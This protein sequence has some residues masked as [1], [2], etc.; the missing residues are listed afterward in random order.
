MA[1]ETVLVLG[2]SGGVGSAAVDLARALGARVLVAVSSQDKLEF[3]KSC[4]AEAGIVY[5]LRLESAEQKKA[6][7]AELKALAGASGVD[8][9]LD[10]VG[11]EYSEPALRCLASLGR[12]LVVGFTAGIPRI[13]LNLVLLNGRKVI[14][15]DWKTL[16]TREPAVARSNL[17]HLFQLWEQGAISPKVTATY[18][19]SQ[20]PEAIE[21]LESRAALG[22]IVVKVDHDA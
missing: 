6:L 8:L 16:V 19:F 21:Q 15:V 10:P 13:P 14:G 22:K 2:A 4:G 17:Q 9:V 20:A 7:S 18:D 5:P 11:G 3:A 1:G 12:Y